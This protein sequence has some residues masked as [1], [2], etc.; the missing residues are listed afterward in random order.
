MHQRFVIRQARVAE[1]DQLTKL[2]L[3]AKAHWGYPK[4]W[5]DLWRADL[6][7][8]PEIIESAMAYV[9]ECEEKIIG[10]WVQTLLD[11]GSDQPMPGWL[12]VHPDHMRQGVARALW[13]ALR[14]EAAARHIGRFVIEA[15]PNAVPFYLALGAQKIG[16]KESTVIPGRHI[17]ILRIAI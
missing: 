8:T 16:A 13:Q 2:V 11:P 10:V 3:L 1:A 9:A 15:D 6:T 7:I 5:L 4:E 14:Q 17:P 12:F